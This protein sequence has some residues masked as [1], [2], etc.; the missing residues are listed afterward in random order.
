MAQTSTCFNRSRPSNEL[1]FGW[2]LPPVRRLTV[3]KR[4]YKESSS[5]TLWYETI[6]S[7]LQLRHQV[8]LNA[9]EEHPLHGFIHYREKAYGT[10]GLRMEQPQIPKDGSLT[11]FL[12]ESINGLF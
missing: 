2:R 7:R 6:L 1:V 5:S 10:I 9:Q 11:N 8:P 4:S 3:R 12:D